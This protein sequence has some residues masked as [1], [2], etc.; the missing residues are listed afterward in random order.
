MPLPLCTQG[1]GGTTP[2]QLR[3]GTVW[4]EA[5]S[6]LFSFLKEQS[7]A[8]IPGAAVSTPDSLH[9]EGF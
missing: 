7:D 4:T 2:G 3:G 8:F 5:F 9:H 6:P 1:S